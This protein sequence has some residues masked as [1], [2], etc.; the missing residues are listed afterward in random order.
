MS[1]I[2]VEI[3][4]VNARGEMTPETSWH[5]GTALAARQSLLVAQAGSAA[6]CRL[7]GVMSNWTFEGTK[8]RLLADDLAEQF[9][10]DQNDFAEID[11]LLGKPVIWERITKLAE[12]LL[13]RNRIEFPEL[14]DFLSA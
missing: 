6:Q 11:D 2:W 8:D 5:A 3:D 12:A 1:V 4:P 13:V 7:N 10:L 9:G 14:A